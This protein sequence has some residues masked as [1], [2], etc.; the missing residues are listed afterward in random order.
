MAWAA[1]PRTSRS[2]SDRLRA[3][4]PPATVRPC[5]C[6]LGRSCLWSPMLIACCTPPPMAAIE[7]ASN[8]SPA[9]S[10][11]KTP[12]PR[13]RCLY[14]AAPV[15]VAP[16]SR[17]SVKTL[18]TVCARMLSSSVF[19]SSY[20]LADAMKSFFASSAIS[21]SHRPAMARRAARV[22][23]GSLPV[24]QRCHRWSGPPTS[25][26]PSSSTGGIDSCARRSGRICSSHT[27]TSDQRGKTNWGDRART[28]SPRVSRS[29]RSLSCRFRS[30]QTRF[31]SALSGLCS[32]TLSH[33]QY[34]E[35][36]SFLLLMPSRATF[37]TPQPFLSIMASRNWSSAWLLDAHKGLACSGRADD[38]CHPVRAR[39]LKRGALCNVK[40]KPVGGEVALDAR[41]HPF[42]P[43]VGR[44]RRVAPF[45]Q[46]LF[47]EG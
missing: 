11:S 41:Q 6:T 13:S 7:C 43:G 44:G 22:S 25:L 5:V 33:T 9:S 27:R 23:P 34:F 40:L 39:M 12:T 28:R 21:S 29:P 38:V 4:G 32:L 8:T 3:Y 2:N 15:V 1:P 19:S 14:L 18:S 26:N 10:I 47:P 35:R 42:R 45:A 46:Q 24:F 36:V 17:A 16:M 37:G 20:F 30:C 31:L